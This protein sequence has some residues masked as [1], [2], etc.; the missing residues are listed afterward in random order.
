MEYDVEELEELKRKLT[1]TIPEEVVS[2]R[3]NAA[4]KQ[5]NREMKIPGFRPGKIPQKVLEK[6]VPMQS[7]GD[8]F[9]ELMQEYYEEALNKSGLR[10]TGQPEIDHAGLQDIKKDEPLKFS[11]VLDIKPE[12]QIKNYKGLKFKKKEAVI[13]DKEMEETQEKV[14]ARHGSLDVMPADHVVALW[15]I[16]KMDFQ[17][18]VDGQPME[19]EKAEDFELRIGEKKMLDG[20][21]NQLIGHKAGEDFEIKVILPPNWN[22]KVQRISFPVPGAEEGEEDDRATFK[23]N[24]KEIKQ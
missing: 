6:Q 22:Q 13:T 21:E 5:L 12:L 2:Q 16:V 1:I 17:G 10:P 23:I 4:Y 14:L 18:F 15:D 9:Q 11:V 7:F 8:M 19:N 20:F 24:I 3:I